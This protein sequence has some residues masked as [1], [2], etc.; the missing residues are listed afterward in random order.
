[1]NNR[2]EQLE[3]A[4]DIDGVIADFEGYAC[5]T[6]GNKNRHLSSL[7]ERYPGKETE[8]DNF[9]N[10]RATYYMLTPE[11]VGIQIAHW[12]MQRVNAYGHRQNRAQVTLL[13]SRPFRVYDVTKNWLKAEKVPYHKLEFSRTKVKWLEE[14][15]PD[16]VVDDII[17]VCEGAALKVPGITPVLISHPWNETP[18]IPRIHSLAAFQSIYQQ[19]ALEK[20][21]DDFG[22]IG[23]AEDIPSP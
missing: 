3:I 14:H 2:K 17:E 23:M 19:V 18:F 8:I 10:N 15:R 16:I 5:H 21:L 6:F 1:M 4:L 22:G 20:L 7:Y 11:P 13:T 12:L 9:L